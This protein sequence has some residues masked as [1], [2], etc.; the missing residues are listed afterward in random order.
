MSKVYIVTGHV[1][2]EGDWIVQV[3]ATRESAEEQA[4]GMLDARL[5]YQTDLE[6]HVE[7]WQVLDVKH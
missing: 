4:Q 1:Q 2:Y 3:H 5:P 6:Y 7:E